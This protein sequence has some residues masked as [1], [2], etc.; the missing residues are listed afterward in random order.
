ML[1][2]VERSSFSWKFWVFLGAGDVLKWANAIRFHGRFQEPSRAERD[3][4][5]MDILSLPA[6]YSLLGCSR[7]LLIAPEGEELME[8]WPKPE[9][10]SPWTSTCSA[11]W[12]LVPLHWQIRGDDQS[13]LHS[14]GTTI[15]CSS[16]LAARTFLNSTSKRLFRIWQMW[17][18]L[19]IV[20]ISFS[21]S[22]HRRS[23]SDCLLQRAP[24]SLQVMDHS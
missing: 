6:K 9:K 15:W 17:L 21:R 8:A 7:K 14:G 10:Q 5:R 22:K 1:L 19:R 2:N 18:F 4:E 23:M 12:Q 11:T 13:T 16:F 20:A 3:F 24:R